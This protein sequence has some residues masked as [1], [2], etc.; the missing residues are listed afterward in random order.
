MSRR[1]KMKSSYRSSCLAV[2]RNS[3]L[4]F[5][6]GKN[7]QGLFSAAAVVTLILLPLRYKNGKTKWKK[8]CRAGPVD[9]HIYMFVLDRCGSTPPKIG[10]RVKLKKGPQ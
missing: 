8:K 4:Y 3:T 7:S 10:W 5:S 1:L 2:L 6:G 9:N